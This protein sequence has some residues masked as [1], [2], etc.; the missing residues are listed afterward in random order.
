MIVDLSRLTHV[1]TIRH[2]LREPSTYYPKGALPQYAKCAHSYSRPHRLP[3]STNRTSYTAPRKTQA[4]RN[5]SLDARYRS[6]S[7]SDE[8]ID[9][10]PIQ[11]SLQPMR[12]TY[13]PHR[14]Q[15]LRYAEYALSH[16]DETLT[17]HRRSLENASKYRNDG[18]S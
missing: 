16:G 2:A 12:R 9:R 10:F 6:W 8:A 4:S 11:N 1:M 13:T 14:Q 3:S 5:A 7:S 17:P 18:T 15:A